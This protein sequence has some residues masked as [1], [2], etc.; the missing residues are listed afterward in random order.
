M[1]GGRWNR[2]D[3]QEFGFTHSRSDMP[4]NIHV[5]KS[6]PGVVRGG[7]Y[8]APRA[9]RLDEIRDGE[10]LRFTAKHFP[11]Q[12]RIPLP[13]WSPGGRSGRERKQE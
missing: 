13:F 2:K 4:V 3:H 9:R 5:G 8:S 11:L 12:G 10:E 7:Y 6:S 1:W